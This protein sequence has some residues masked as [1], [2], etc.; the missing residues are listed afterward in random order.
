MK[1]DNKYNGYFE[2]GKFIS[3][4]EKIAEHK[5]NLNKLKEIGIHLNIKDIDGRRFGQSASFELVSEEGYISKNEIINFFDDLSTLTIV[6]GIFVLGFILG[7]I[8]KSI[9]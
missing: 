7:F 3:M 1:Y 8:F 2:N 4:K 5:D 9:S 6:F